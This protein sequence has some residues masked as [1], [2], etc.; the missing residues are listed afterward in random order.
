[1]AT[2]RTRLSA[3][4]LISLF[5]ISACSGGLSGASPAASPTA[6]TTAGA[7]T[8]TTAP[9]T[10]PSEAAA[11]VKLNYM[12]GDVEAVQTSAHAFA[13]AY[14]KLHPNVTFEFD[15]IPG[16]TEG[17][18]LLKTRLSTG[19]GG[20][21]IWYNSG[22][23]L[24]ALNPAESLVDVSGEPWIANLADSFIPTVSVGKQIF[25]AP[26]GTA[27]GGGIL[28]NKKVFAAN[29]ITV[30][31]TW[32]EFEANNDKLKAAGVAPLGATFGGT[33][34]WTSQL[35]VLADSCNVQ[36]AVPNFAA[37]YT[38]N[39]VHYADTP[40]ALKGFQRLQE[41]FD[42][43]WWQKDFGSAKLDDGLN[44]LATGKIAQYPMLTFA[45][46]TIQA[47]HPEA[48]NDI[49]FFGQPGDDASKNCATIWMPSA[50]YIA[51]T[52]KNIDAAKDFLG[53]IASTAGSD[54][55]TAAVPP[56]GPYVIKGATLPAD[57]MPAVK[58]IQP[59]IDG[60]NNAPALEFLSPV[61]GPSLEQ[62]TVAVGSGLSSAEDAAK[63][64]DKDVAKQAKQLGL[65]G[66]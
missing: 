36:A 47:N 48:I 20:D 8:A 9:T 3:L 6:A 63:L 28:Y 7:S 65:P 11:P 39:K 19:D 10:A 46:S 2:A 42:K 57:A 51:K 59:Y 14:T 31:K 32:A 61:K 41:S 13:D 22:S 55:L 54:A 62:F 24:Q 12:V 29:G 1:M 45:L 64:Y 4:A 52:S 44:A 30:P 17:D 26:V 40:A 60:G 53:F 23:L 18:N 25:G 27:M 56:T 38:A 66:W 33:D 50:T 43:K 21:L 37:D 16:G 35:F 58:D 49:G 15:V 34:T 5:A